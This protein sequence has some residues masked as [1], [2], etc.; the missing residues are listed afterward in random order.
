MFALADYRGECKFF[1][2]A[3]QVSTS[4]SA[5][6]KAL[7]GHADTRAIVHLPSLD[8]I[9]NVDDGVI[10]DCIIQDC[11]PMMPT[12]SSNPHLRR[13]LFASLVMYH[14]DLDSKYSPCIVVQTLISK[15]RCHN[16]NEIKLNCTDEKDYENNF[17]EV[18]AQLSET[19]AS[20]AAIQAENAAI[21]IFSQ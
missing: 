3:L 6:S 1:E 16:I 4:M 14:N 12:L 5:G 10:I 15:C 11:F 19:R 7:A 18:L 8:S 13:V 20:L 9:Y 2:Y 21:K 17:E